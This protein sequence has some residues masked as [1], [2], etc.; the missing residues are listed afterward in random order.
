MNTTEPIRDLEQVHELASFYIKK[1]QLRNHVLILLG[2]YTALRVSDILRLVW[3]DVFDFN[4]GA[5]RA[6]INIVEKKTGKSKSIALNDDVVSAL[7]MLAAVSARRGAPLILNPRTGEAISR[8]HAYRVTRAAGEA[9]GF[10][11]RISCHSLRKTFGY[12]AWRVGVDPV[13]LVSIFNHSS[14][15]ITMRYLGITQDEKD[16]VYLGISFLGTA[17]RKSASNNIDPVHR[18]FAVAKM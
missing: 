18:S 8:N 2:L 4:V 17:S 14:L 15:D 11:F 1:G 6:S 13:L 9:L 10:G 5:V 7:T 3:D 12:H 16:A